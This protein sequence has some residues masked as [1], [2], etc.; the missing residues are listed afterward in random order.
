MD[1]F[2]FLYK[3][4]CMGDRNIING[5]ITVSFMPFLDFYKQM[6]PW[7][8]FAVILIIADCR[9]GCAAARK[10]GEKVRGSRKWRRSINKSI[11]YLCWITV[12]YLCSHSVGEVVGK[13]VVSMVVI[14]IVYGI[15]LTSCI[16]NYLEA[17][18]ITKRIDFFKVFKKGTEKIPLGDVFEDSDTNEKKD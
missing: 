6:L 9:F 11:D 8:L 7:L 16:N 2:L 15:E 10:R 12:A 18:G 14:F 4:Y 17:K 3:R 13:P 1:F 5:V